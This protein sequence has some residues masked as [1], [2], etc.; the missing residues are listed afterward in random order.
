MAALLHPGNPRSSS[1][2]TDASALRVAC[3]G[4]LQKRDM[5][6]KGEW[7]VLDTVEVMEGGG[8]GERSSALVVG[9]VLLQQP[10]H[11]NR[12]DSEMV[13][14]TGIIPARP[15]WFAAFHHWSSG[16]SSTRR[17]SPLRKG[18]SSSSF[19]GK[20]NSARTNSA[21]SN[22]TP[23]AEVL[24]NPVCLALF[25]GSMSVVVSR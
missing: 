24:M 23:T 13:K 5:T 11:N 20:S 8:E 12:F 7:D 10:D 17:M 21:S 14:G 19:P 25:M 6:T 4:R 2:L 15:S 18:R 1:S 16:F 22:G 9:M 3:S